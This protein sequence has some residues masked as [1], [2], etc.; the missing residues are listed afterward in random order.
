MQFCDITDDFVKRKNLTCGSDFALSRVLLR[1]LVSHFK[2]TWVQDID[3][4][5]V[6]KREM[7]HK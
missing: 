3:S 2:E 6:L 1:R 4:V 7:E 5:W